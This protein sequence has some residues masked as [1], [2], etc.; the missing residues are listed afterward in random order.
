MAHFIEPE[1]ADYACRRGEL[2]G[3]VL[4]YGLREVSRQDDSRNTVH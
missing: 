1:C 3:R 4:C 2:A